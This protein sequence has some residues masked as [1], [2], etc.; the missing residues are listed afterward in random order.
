[1]GR[2]LSTPFDCLVGLPMAFNI[3]SCAFEGTDAIDSR[4]YKY[5][6]DRYICYC[7]QS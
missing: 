2:F 6:K 3:G 5:H 4:V 7:N 1:V